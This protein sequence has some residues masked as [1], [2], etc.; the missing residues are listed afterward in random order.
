MYHLRESLGVSSL[1]R[2][3]SWPC[4]ARHRFQRVWK[5]SQIPKQHKSRASG[6]TQQPTTKAR[7][8][9]QPDLGGPRLCVQGRGLWG[10]DNLDDDPEFSHDLCRSQNYVRVVPIESSKYPTPYVSNPLINPTR[11]VSIAESR[12]ALK[13]SFNRPR[14]R[15]QPALNQNG[16]RPS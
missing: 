1:H 15:S 6:N 3:L 10:V 8:H 5:V 16:A 11:H 4:Q 7:F 13:V 2:V 12:S 14:P 9:T